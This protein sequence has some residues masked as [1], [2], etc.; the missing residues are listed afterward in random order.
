MFILFTTIRTVYDVMGEPPSDRGGE[1]DI[2]T[3]SWSITDKVALA[4]GPGTSK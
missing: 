4:G 3:A 1:N 2:R